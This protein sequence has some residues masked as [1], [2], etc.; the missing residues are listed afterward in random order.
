MAKIFPPSPPEGC[1]K[2]ELKVRNALG[3]ADN[4]TL[5]HSVV[6]QSRRKGIQSDGEADFIILHPRHGIAI[7]EVKG[8]GIEIVDGKWYSTDAQNV[9]HPIKNPFEQAKDS[10]YAL[11]SYL[12]A[13]DKNLSQIPVVHGVIFPDI[14]VDTHFGMSGPREITI[15][16]ND[17]SKP[18]NALSRLFGYWEKSHFIAQ[19]DVDKLISC[20]APTTTIR[21][22]LADEVADAERALIKLTQEQARILQALKRIPHAAILGGAGTGKTVIAIEKARQLAQSGFRTLLLCYNEPL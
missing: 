21:R 22:R 5:L 19:S 18:G 17:L 13:I 14:T 10:K 8:G 20:L 2:S 6:W 9:R 15:D 3:Q 4:L 7:I 1:P 11:V 12:K 16:K